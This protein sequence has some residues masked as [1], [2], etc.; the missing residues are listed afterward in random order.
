MVSLSRFID[1]ARIASPPEVKSGVAS[2]KLLVLAP[3]S[4]LNAL[5]CYNASDEQHQPGDQSDVAS[6][7]PGR[8]AGCLQICNSSKRVPSLPRLCWLRVSTSNNSPAPAP[9][10]LQT[11]KVSQNVPRTT[12][13]KA[14]ILRISGPAATERDGPVHAAG[15][16]QRTLAMCAYS[17]QA[18]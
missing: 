10:V 17:E 6:A 2:P 1:L 12:N 7:S 18:Q 14:S 9:R 8:L 16:E 3:S 13:S 15:Y 5:I 4:F 11:R